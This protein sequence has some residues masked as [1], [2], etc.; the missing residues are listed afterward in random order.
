MGKEG[1]LWGPGGK[2]PGDPAQQGSDLPRKGGKAGQKDHGGSGLHP[3]LLALLCCKQFSPQERGT[4]SGSSTA[5]YSWGL[6]KGL[7]QCGWREIW[8][9]REQSR[10]RVTVDEHGMLAFEL[11]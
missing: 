10:H 2:R 9:A 7:C 4:D 8:L 5:L 3:L 1:C 6:G 11:N